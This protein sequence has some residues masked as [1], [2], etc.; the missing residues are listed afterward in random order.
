[1]KKWAMLFIGL[2]IVVATSL[3]LPAAGVTVVVANV[4][5]EPMREV[6]VHVTGASYPIGELA[7]GARASV[8]AKPKGDSH[9]EIGQSSGPRLIVDCYFE[10][11]YSGTVTAEVTSVKVLAVNSEVTP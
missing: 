7:P 3:V 4:G 9:V 2:A 1:M 11:G 10:S 8:V 6:V 5:T